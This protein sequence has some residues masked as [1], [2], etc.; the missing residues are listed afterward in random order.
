MAG[1]APLTS[2]HRVQRSPISGLDTAIGL[3]DAGITGGFVHETLDSWW[4]E[5]RK[6]GIKV[7]PYVSLIELE[8][9]VFSG[10]PKIAVVKIRCR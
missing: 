10:D 9:S 1:S 7:L 4:R 2:A 6:T 5:L 3:F 8:A